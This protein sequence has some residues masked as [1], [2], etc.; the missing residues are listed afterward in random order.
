MSFGFIFKASPI[1]LAAFRGPDE[2]ARYR[3]ISKIT[4]TGITYQIMFASI[5]QRVRIKVFGC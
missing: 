4:A 5:F 1:D 3:R 2:M